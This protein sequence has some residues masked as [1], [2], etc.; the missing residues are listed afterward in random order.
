[1]K[2][3]YTLF[4]LSAALFSNAQSILEKKITISILDEKI[5]DAL[6][7]LSKEGN[8]AFSYNSSLLPREQKVTLYAFDRSLREILD[9]IF[10]GSVQYKE[11]GKYLILKKAAIATKTSQVI[12]S[13][14]I[15]DAATGG[16]IEN[17]SVYDK[18][19]ITSVI[20]DEIGFFQLK[21]DKN[22]DSIQFAISKKKYIDTLVTL[23]AR[24]Y[25]SVKI[26]IRSKTI[27][28]TNQAD[29][30]RKENSQDKMSM[31]YESVPHVQN[32]SDTIYRDIQIS[33]LPFVGS[34]E[35]LSGNAI[36]NYSINILGGYSLGTRQIELGFFFNVDRGDVSWLQIAGVGNL[37]G[38][39]VYGVQAAGFA[40]I[41]GGET[42]ALQ[43]AG[44]YNGNRGELHGVQVA[45]FVNTNLQSVYGIQASGFHNL[46]RGDSRG[47][48]AT[49]GVNISLGNFKGT[50][51]AGA[52]NLATM[53]MYGSQIAAVA[54]VATK[55][56]A[57]SQIAGV[58]NYSKN[59]QGTQ[60]GLLNYADTLG[61]VPIGL[62][63][64]VN[65]GY[66]KI[67]LSAD[68][69]FYTNLA[70]RTGVRK[71][72]TILLVGIQPNQ[73]LDKNY[74][75]TFG[76]GLG[77]ARRITRG[78]QLN[79]DATAQHVT[80]SSF[81][82]SLSLL[83]KVHVGLDF[84]LARKFWIYGGITLNGYLSNPTISDTPSL[85]TNYQPE[86]ISERNIDGSHNL[87]MWW[88]AKVA[89]R[90]L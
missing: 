13:G 32:I 62:I 14:F 50:Q 58:F 55:R 47:V 51:V 35:R 80:K 78:I 17:A 6:A 69:I 48:Q 18:H 40:N 44:F 31:P 65:Q 37:V 1:M 49:G 20:T 25:N 70:F 36:N 76:Y 61:G 84:K 68:E 23:P 60:I 41:N 12:V 88:G 89:L 45:G 42:K 4:F 81:T 74:L 29:T 77:T 38:Q 15:E 85:I 63:S 11:K 86:I 83:N 30:V 26:R 9:E 19:S 34:N 27:A 3:L 54:N 71:F 7:K 24:N 57:G 67:E 2:K 16:K 52:M 59:V 82:H 21:L 22:G 28:A 56:V 87:K 8:F 43:L 10:K 73:V 39:N 53:N 46:A 79:V 5:P 72:Y 66:H 64:Y 90:F 33:L 75:W